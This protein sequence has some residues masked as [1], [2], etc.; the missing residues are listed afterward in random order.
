[1]KEKNAV[2]EKMDVFS[3]TQIMLKVLGLY[4]PES[5]VIKGTDPAKQVWKAVK[6]L[7]SPA[8]TKSAISGILEA[9]RDNVPGMSVAHLNEWVQ[10]ASKGLC[11][12]QDRL[13]ISQFIEEFDKTVKVTAGM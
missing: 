2:S 7:E 4:P 13:D 6:R 1:M 8:G 11:R 9:Q 10:L 5:M 3:V 12:P